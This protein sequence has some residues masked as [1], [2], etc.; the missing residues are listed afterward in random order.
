MVSNRIGRLEYLF[1]CSVPIVV[2]SVL[3]ELIGLSIGV[4]NLQ[5]DDAAVRRVVTP[6]V[7]IVAV[8]ILRAG[9]SRFHDIGWS[10]WFV[11]LMFVPLLN[12]IIFLLLVLIP[13]QKTGNKYGDPPLLFGRLRGSGQMP[14][15]D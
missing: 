3:A 8:I 5:S 12:L 4:I 10:G 13:G 7:L 2:G 6:V 15:P 9:V 11:L 1:W 14:A